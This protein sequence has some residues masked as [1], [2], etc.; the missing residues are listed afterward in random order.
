M[1][2]PGVAVV[3]EPEVELLVDPEVVV[4]SSPPA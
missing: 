3:V 2:T 4:P 1:L